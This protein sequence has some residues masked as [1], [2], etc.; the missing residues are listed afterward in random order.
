MVYFNGDRKSFHPILIAIIYYFPA[1]SC[2]G[3]EQNSS[4]PQLI[5]L[6]LFTNFE[7]Y[8]H[9]PLQTQCMARLNPHLP[10][11]EF[12]ITPQATLTQPPS[13][14]NGTLKV[15]R[16]RR[17]SQDTPAFNR[18]QDTKRFDKFQ[19]SLKIVDSPQLQAIL[20]DT[21]V[22]DLGR[23]NNLDDALTIGREAIVRRILLNDAVETECAL[24]IEYIWNHFIE[25]ESQCPKDAEKIAEWRREIE[26]QVSAPTLRR[27]LSIAKKTRDRMD[28]YTSKPLAFATTCQLASSYPLKLP[29]IAILLLTKLMERLIRSYS[30]CLGYFALGNPFS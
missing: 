12:V 25:L 5:K 2:L 21:D 8:V 7:L 28:Q 11:Q 15:T 17:H 9:P 16:A 22:H 4:S 27:H 10:L 14:D 3:N 13:E 24:K 18:H 29:P 1:L 20:D 6:F 26:N 23:T 30:I 19:S